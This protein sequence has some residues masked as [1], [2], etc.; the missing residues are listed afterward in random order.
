VVRSLGV[1]LCALATFVAGVL[2]VYGR[3]TTVRSAFIPVLI[4]HHVKLT[5]PTDD[6]TERGLTISPQQFSSELAYLQRARY[7]TITAD[8]LVSFFHGRASLPS[9]PVMLTFD[10]GYVDVYHA[11][12]S[13]LRE[14]HMTAIF[15]IVPGFLGRQ[16]YMNAAQVRDMADHGMDIEA[17]TMTHPDLTTLPYRSALRE[18][19]ISR[20]FLQRLIRHSVRAFAYP[21]GAYNRSTLQAVAAS[22]FEVAFSTRAGWIQSS[23]AALTLPRV[24]ID[25]DDSL[26]NFAA[27]LHRDRGVLLADPT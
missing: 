1:L 8:R 18:I 27:R 19:K 15:F 23:E 25:A 12:Y 9:R 20:E 16:R 11:V 21:Y 10:D 17:H 13:L 7:H 14:R 5:R 4:Y 6:A 2:P 26:P 3:H 24:Y 22:Q